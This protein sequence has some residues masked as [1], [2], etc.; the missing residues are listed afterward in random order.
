MDRLFIE[1]SLDLTKNICWSECRGLIN[2]DLLDVSHLGI[3]KVRLSG[4]CCSDQM[5]KLSTILD[6]ETTVKEMVPEVKFLI[7]DD[8]LLRI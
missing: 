7:E 4:N 6:I 2:I 8:W 5:N 3:V 1:S